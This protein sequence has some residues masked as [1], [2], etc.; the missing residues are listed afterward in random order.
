MGVFFP[1]LFLRA[2]G[3]ASPCFSPSHLLPSHNRT[4]ARRLLTS[5]ILIAVMPCQ[6]RAEI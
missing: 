6:V 4:F 1:I 2:W 5:H 3:G